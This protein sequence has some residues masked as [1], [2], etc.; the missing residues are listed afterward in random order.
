MTTRRHIT[1]AAPDPTPRR[2]TVEPTGY[3]SPTYRAFV[4]AQTR[5]AKETAADRYQPPTTL[6]E[7]LA[8]RSE[9]QVRTYNEHRERYD[10]L[11]RGETAPQP[12]ASREALLAMTHA[13]AMRLRDTDPTAYE[14]LMSGQ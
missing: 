11:M 8:M 6:A 2:R 13:E 12:P 4:E 14:R 3:V 9:D 5:L 10:A 1:A 7:L